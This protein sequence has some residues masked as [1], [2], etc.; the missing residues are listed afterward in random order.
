MSR[1][2]VLGVS[3]MFV[4]VP[5]VPGAPE[6]RKTVTMAGAPQKLGRYELLE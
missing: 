2:R 5:L 1:V 6:T 4:G 3:E